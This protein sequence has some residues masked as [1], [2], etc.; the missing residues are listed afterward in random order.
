MVPLW[1]LVL[2]CPPT[3][4]SKAKNER[5][6]WAAPRA[7]STVYIILMF[8][9]LDNKSLSAGGWLMYSPLGHHECRRT[10]AWDGLRPWGDAAWVLVGRCARAES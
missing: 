4:T 9:R 1:G 3:D 6:C 7:L 2:L 8:P 5:G 10:H